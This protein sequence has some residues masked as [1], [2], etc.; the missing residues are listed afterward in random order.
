MTSLCSLLFLDNLLPFPC[1]DA[2]HGVAS[3]L[4]MA[5]KIML[6]QILIDGPA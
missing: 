4:T 2:F 1:K 3:R 6:S 5:L